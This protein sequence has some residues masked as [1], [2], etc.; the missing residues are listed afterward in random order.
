MNICDLPTNTLNLIFGFSNL[1]NITNIKLVCKQFRQLISTPGYEY[2][3]NLSKTERFVCLLRAIQRNDSHLCKYLSHEFEDDWNDDLF[4]YVTMQKHVEMPYF[5][6]LVSKF[7]IKESNKKY[8]FGKTD[9]QLHEFI[10]KYPN[11]ITNEL[12]MNICEKGYESCLKFLLDNDYTKQIE[13]SKGI[14][15]IC[16]N[17]HVNCLKLILKDKRIDPSIKKN[18]PLR[19]ASYTRDTRCLEL[20][21]Q[22]DR[23]DPRDHDSEAVHLTLTRR[24][25]VGLQ[26]LLE[27]GLPGGTHA[28]FGADPRAN[29][30]SAIKYVCE[31]NLPECLELLLLDKRADPTV[32]NNY[33]LQQV[34][35][36]CSVDCLN[37]LLQDGRA[38]PS[39]NNSLLVNNLGNRNLFDHCGKLFLDL[40]LKDG[41]LDPAAHNN[42][43][44]HYVVTYSTDYDYLK[45][46]IKD[47][48]IDFDFILQEICIKAD[49]GALNI[50]LTETNAN[51][52]NIPNIYQQ[53]CQNIDCLKIILKDGL[54]GGAHAGFGAPPDNIFS[55]MILSTPIRYDASRQVLTKL[56]L[57]DGRADPSKDSHIFEVAIQ[58]REVGCLKLLLD[59]PRIDIRTNNF[60][61]LKYTGFAKKYDESRK[62]IFAHMLKNNIPFPDSLKNRAMYKKY[63]EYERGF[64]NPTKSFDIEKEQDKKLLFSE[65]NR[66]PNS[67]VFDIYQ[68]VKK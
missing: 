22:D 63:I 62:A 45:M 26:L 17:G 32:D 52:A 1:D 49:A 2:Y 9:Q 7:G 4:Q 67:N 35:N 18:H 47:G 55:T 39:A 53:L 57:E 11:I 36:K 42:I 10:N 59:D 13:K 54:P 64:V 66:Q 41:R 56:F 30:N 15:F 31:R 19:W 46:L 29:N 33:C 20:L 5:D 8:I 16:K 27:D 68:L 6:Y 12:V 65:L 37:L 44:I 60:K 38:D 43:L 25:K 14:I 24:N 28:G 3:L 23:T 50:I 48:R 34:C 21:L 61:I 58:N 40:L 51:P